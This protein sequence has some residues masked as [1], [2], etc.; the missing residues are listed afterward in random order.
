MWA[1]STFQNIIKSTFRP[2]P[3]FG[4]LHIIFLFPVLVR[5]TTKMN[6]LTWSWQAATISQ[7]RTG[8]MSRSPPRSVLDTAVCVNWLAWLTGKLCKDPGRRGRT[9]AGRPATRTWLLPSGMADHG[10]SGHSYTSQWW[11]LKR[12]WWIDGTSHGRAKP[13]LKIHRSKSGMSG[14]ARSITAT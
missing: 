12:I 6:F 7:V 2:V 8:M 10:R 3:N 5:M 11:P 13:V 1:R 14:L 4:L 9:Q